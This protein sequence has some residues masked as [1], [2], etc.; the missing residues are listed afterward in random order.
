MTVLSALASHQ[1]A[2]SQTRASYPGPHFA[3]DWAWGL[4]GLAG[5]TSI[6]HKDTD[7]LATMS[8]PF[9]GSKYWV[10]FNPIE[11][12]TSAR[13][14]IA[15]INVLLAMDPYEAPALEKYSTEG[16]L[17]ESNSVL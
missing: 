7:G 14:D 5:A 2:M 3:D 15:N 9:N 17:I 11:N 12:S 6:P 10:V 16:V 8:R 1:V 13:A 4:V